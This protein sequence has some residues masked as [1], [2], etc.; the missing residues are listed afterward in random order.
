LKKHKLFALL[1]LIALFLVILG[2]IIIYHPAT[3]SYNDKTPV[4]I[5]V[6]SVASDHKLFT[7]EATILKEVVENNQYRLMIKTSDGG[8]G[9]V[10][11][12][13]GCMYIVQIIT[14]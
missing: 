9:W 11:I 6:L 10:V 3:Y 2:F 8:V 7:F 13:N 1:G 12:P 14:N 4:Q 5:T